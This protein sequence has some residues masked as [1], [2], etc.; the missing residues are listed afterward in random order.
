MKKK[1]P[2][3]SVIVSVQGKVPVEG[4]DTLSHRFPKGAIL[5]IERLGDGSFAIGVP[6]EP[7]IPMKT[8]HEWAAYHKSINELESKA[9]QSET[10]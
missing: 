3:R 4:F 2:D 7:P 9:G 1:R 8:K 5:Q 6:E 10:N